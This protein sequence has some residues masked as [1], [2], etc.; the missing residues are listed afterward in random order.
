MLSDP[1]IGI[2]NITRRSLFPFCLFLF[3]FNTLWKY[4]LYLWW[5]VSP[6]RGACDRRLWSVFSYVCCRVLIDLNSYRNRVLW[7]AQSGRERGGHQA[8]ARGRKAT[9]PTEARVEDLQDVDGRTGRAMD[10][11]VWQTGGLQCDG[12]RSARPFARRPL[13]TVQS[14]VFPQDRHATR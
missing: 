1:P 6:R 3:P 4:G 14:P 9:E 10:D 11:L 7:S 12:N 2:T 5:Q 8:R 13:Q